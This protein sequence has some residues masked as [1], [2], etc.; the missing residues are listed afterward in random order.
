M[1]TIAISRV[2]NELVECT[3]RK[4]ASYQVVV[5]SNGQ[6]FVIMKIVLFKPK[7]VEKGFE[8]ARLVCG[9]AIYSRQQEGFQRDNVGL[10]P[11]NSVQPGV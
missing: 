6:G 5:L 3:P 9:I 1:P 10:L 11:T 2:G 7:P 8:V 4:R